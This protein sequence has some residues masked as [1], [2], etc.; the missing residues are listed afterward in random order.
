MSVS[1]SADSNQANARLRCFPE[2]LDK[3]RTAVIVCDQD[4]SIKLVNSSAEELL[5]AS[6]N[7]VLADSVVEYFTQGNVAELFRSCLENTQSTTVRQTE[8]LNSHRRRNLVDCLVTPMQLEGQDYLV[9]ELNEVN[10][11]AEQS[12]DIAR[13][14]GQSA[15]TAVLRAIAHEIKNPLGGLRGAAQLLERKLATRDYMRQY[16][17]IIV[18]ETDRLCSLVDGMSGIRNR[19]QFTRVNVHEAL[20]HVRNLVQAANG[21]AVKVALDYDP[22]LP[23]VHGDLEHLI[24]VFLNIVQNAIEAGGGDVELTLHTRVLRQATIGHQR[25]QSVARIDIQ[26]NGPGIPQPMQE[27]VFLPLISSKTHGGG[28]GLAIAH[29]IIRMHGGDITCSSEPGNTCFTVLLKF[30]HCNGPSEP[31][32]MTLKSTIS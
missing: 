1:R 25:Y 13:Q 7:V 24:Q 3:L 23:A 30:A 2:L 11:V 16:T 22:S 4:L 21:N 27:Q 9:L 10:A 28:L 20:E 5:D 14:I 32:L 6:E 31:V 17:R 15:N 29:E 26:D 19:P 18:K 12:S 8:I